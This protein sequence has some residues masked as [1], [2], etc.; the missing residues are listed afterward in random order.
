MDLKLNKHL[1]S[2]HPAT[3]QPHGHRLGHPVTVGTGNRLPINGV[4]GGGQRGQVG[5]RLNPV[6]SHSGDT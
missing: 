1:R 5:R 2:N 3:G 4:R 6:P